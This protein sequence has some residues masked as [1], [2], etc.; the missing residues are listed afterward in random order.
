MAKKQN[1]CEKRNGHRF[2]GSNAD[3]ESYENMTLEVTC[4]DCEMRWVA[5]SNWEPVNE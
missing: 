5:E 4:L 2:D 1:E 3:S